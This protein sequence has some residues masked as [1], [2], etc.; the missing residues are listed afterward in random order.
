MNKN[1]YNLD[2]TIS[3]ARSVFAKKPAL[4]MAT[5]SGCLYDLNN[6]RFTVPYLGQKYG[7]SYPEGHVSD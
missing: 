5:N 1:P 3:V 7:V 4:E 2:E 6:Q